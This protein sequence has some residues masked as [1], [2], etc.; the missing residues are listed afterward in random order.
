MKYGLLLFLFLSL[1]TKVRAQ[2]IPYFAHLNNIQFNPA[3]AGSTEN[4]EINLLSNSLMAN[5]NYNQTRAL[6][7]LYIFSAEADIERFSS[8][9]G[10]IF[11]YYEYSNVKQYSP[12]LA[13]N[14]KIKFSKISNLRLGVQLTYTQSITSGDQYNPVQKTQNY[15][16]V[17][18]GLW[19]K[20]DKLNIGLSLNSD[21]THHF[22]TNYLNAF[23][24]FELN[25][26]DIT[27]A[28]IYK[29]IINNGSPD[30]SY[31][32]SFMVKKMFMLGFYY[33]SYDAYDFLSAY[34]GIKLDNR[35][36][37]CVS[38]N[39]ALNLFPENFTK[40]G[41]SAKYEFYSAKKRIIKNDSYNEE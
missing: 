20:I 18:I 5:Y 37:L 9:V 28:I 25:H 12:A 36:S 24:T 38:Y 6:P 21:S 15:F 22:N 2:E 31:F 39:K 13:Y 29:T 3:S 4:P 33:N 14:Y 17:N 8:G 10:T 41:L 34:I 40:W 35:A 11:R 7:N 32:L 1:Y 26:L 27:P 19:Y 23:Y 30:I 16:Y